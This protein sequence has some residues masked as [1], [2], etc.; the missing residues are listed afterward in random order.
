MAERSYY[1]PD[2]QSPTLDRGSTSSSGPTPLSMPRDDQN[3]LADG[4]PATE[5]L[6][7]R[8]QMAGWQD[9]VEQASLGPGQRF[10]ESIGDPVD[11]S[12]LQ[13]GNEGLMDIDGMMFPD[14]N[15][16]GFQD[17]TQSG[18]HEGQTAA[19]FPGRLP[20]HQS[21][22]EDY[23]GSHGSQRGWEDQTADAG[24]SPLPWPGTLA[25]IYWDNKPHP[26]RNDFDPPDRPG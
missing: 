25:A 5:E 1:P 4:L 20:R 6:G 26:D 3:M 7:M 16:L 9:E 13:N 18:S 24:G 14:V 11:P 8:K 12:M 22:Q 10:Q 19:Q 21:L 17:P 23:F 2:F 15:A